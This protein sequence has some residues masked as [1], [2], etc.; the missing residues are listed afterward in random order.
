MKRWYLLWMLCPLAF[1]ACAQIP[2]AEKGLQSPSE[3]SGESKFEEM[4]HI[5]E[6]GGA[7]IDYDTL[8]HV[9]HTLSQSR[10]EI[11]HMDLLLEALMDKRN[12]NPR[13]DQMILIFTA[14]AIGGSRY[15]I[16]HVGDLFKR[17]LAKD[18]RL[19]QWVLAFVADAI[20]NYAVDIRE[21]E[22]LVDLVEKKLA[23]VRSA[24]RPP[25]EYFGYHFLPP[26]KGHYI[27]SYIAGIKEQ[28][29]RERERRHYY[30]LIV[31][32]YSE[33]K[34]EKALKRLHADQKSASE[35]QSIGEMT[36]LFL[37]LHKIP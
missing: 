20:G 25:K 36:Y 22:K 29:Q 30:L 16:S 34:I 33:S 37:N 28:S 1:V 13:I 31:N 5:L 11:P 14:K 19:S 35:A 6:T 9:Y 26:P 3:L 24:S 21:G 7:E 17:L 2:A 27:R 4:N 18:D 10:H 23:M 15:P 12:D 32:G 8:M